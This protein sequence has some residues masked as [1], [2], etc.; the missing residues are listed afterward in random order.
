MLGIE[1]VKTENNDSSL[2]AAMLAG[3]AAGAFSSFAESVERCVRIE[4]VVKP[5][6]E[7]FK[8]YEKQFT[9]YKQIH[10]ALA[11]V[12]HAMEG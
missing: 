11:P 12:Y 8:I 2:G 9:L 3:V 10:D 6:P 4:Q 7:N 1:L 5:D